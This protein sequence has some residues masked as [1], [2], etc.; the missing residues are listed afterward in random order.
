MEGKRASLRTFPSIEAREAWVMK[1]TIVLADDHHVVRQG[2][3]AMLMSESDFDVIGEAGDGLEAV[4][5]VER[6][7]PR[8][9]VLDLMMPLLNGLEV[10]RQV[11]QRTKT[12]VVVLSMHASDA[13]ISEALKNGAS[14]YVLKDSQSSELVQA[15]RE[16]AAGNAI[17]VHP[18]RSARWNSM[19]EGWL[20]F[21]TIR[22]IS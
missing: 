6:L 9:V 8:I 4:R 7:K 21:P 14:G 17:S 2:L 3:K 18:C 10:A 16:V 15:I 5:I 1:I 20:T 11:T 12:R 13:Y 19:A 22:T